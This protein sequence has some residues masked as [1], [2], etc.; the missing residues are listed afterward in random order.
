V[1]YAP[2][3]PGALGLETLLLEKAVF[4]PCSARSLGLH[5]FEQEE[6]ALIDVC[7]EQASSCL[8]Y[9]CPQPL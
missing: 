1:A 4:S 6:E 2:Y 8:K 7:F 3:C 9:E 5:G